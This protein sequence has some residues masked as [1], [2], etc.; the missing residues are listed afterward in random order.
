MI[1]KNCGKIVIGT[2][3]CPNCKRSVEV[4]ETEATDTVHTEVSDNHPS[5]L[6][7]KDVLPEINN[8]NV[9]KETND[10]THPMK[11]HMVML[12]FLWL[13]IIIN[14]LAIIGFMSLSGLTGIICVVMEIVLVIF[15]FV[16]WL[17][18]K[19]HKKIGPKLLTI[20][21][22]INI[23]LYVIFIGY[24]AWCYSSVRRFIRSESFIFNMVMLIF[25][26]II[27]IIN[28]KYYKKRVDVFVN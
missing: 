20:L 4:Y 15:S 18:L 10:V 16:V 2:S 12:V 14:V 23:I 17:N 13:G 28:H 21:N 22:V 24:I 19:N 6:I 8:L 3:K 1:C 5:E 9:S 7:P 27:A 26:I 25:L 11:W